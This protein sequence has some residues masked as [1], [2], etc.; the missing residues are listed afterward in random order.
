[1]DWR[2]TLSLASE[3]A[4][5]R[6]PTSLSPLRETWLRFRLSARSVAL[7]TM[8][9]P[10]QDF[11]PNS[12]DNVARLTGTYLNNSGNGVLDG[13][14]YAYNPL[15]QRTNVIRNYW[16][17]SATATVGY[18][19]I[20][21]LISWTAQET[22]GTAR[23]NEQLGYAYDAGGN[24]KQRTNNTLMQ[25]FTVDPANALTN[26]ART[27][28]LTV[29]GNTSLPAH[30]VTV[31]GQP[32]FTYGDFT[33]ASSNGFALADGQNSFTN[34]AS[35]YYGISGVTNTLAANLP[36]SV[37]LQYDP[38]GNL[39]GDGTRCFAYDDENQLTSVWQ[40]NQWRSDF[41][42]DARLRRRIKRDYNWVGG[43]WT[44]TNE[45]RFIYDGQ[46]V[47]QE[48]D[49]N[50][51]AQVTYT[52]GLDLS[53]SLQGAGGIGGLL[54]RTDGTGSTF[55]H[56]DGNGNVTSLVDA[57]QYMVAR[58]LYDPF[59]K[60]L[61][62]WGA[63]ADANLYRFSSKEYH[64]NSG[65][66]YYGFRFYDPN[67]QRWPNPDPIGELGG[68]DLYQYCLNDPLVW[69]DAFGLDVKGG[70]LLM[71][72]NNGY[73]GLNPLFG[74]LWNSPNTALGLLWGG[75]GIPFGAK[76]S[77]ANNALQF[78]N[79]PFQFGG[80]ITLGNVT[81]YRKGMGPKDPLFPGSPYN[82]S[83]H[84]RQHTYQGE[85]LG[86][87]FFPAYGIL[88][89]NSLLHGGDF[90]GAGNLMETGPYLPE[91]TSPPVPPRPWP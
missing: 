76:P 80:D 20:G 62:K 24:L 6:D 67:L 73:G 50:N 11:Q 59:G 44:Q 83:D 52:R 48:W 1:L 16:W 5:H 28:P 8:P 74:Y 37:N 61:G 25:T 34:V 89:V 12:Y 2:Q 4:R 7:E 9:S 49:S 36:A 23:L 63:L 27:G 65:L 71:N 33:F 78:E 47:I 46:A 43:S 45:V 85:Q 86:P 26:V 51:V 56:A 54:A 64:L 17:T 90:F 81:C 10:K 72:M 70:Q 91:T 82:F 75:L 69:D 42:Y 55:Y 66:Y 21:Q 30:S 88:G 40:T 31:N 79:H 84:E 18:D 32:A 29:S 22:N 41:V 53:G 13:Y 15:G 87:F 77:F 68:L 14:A 3:I 19:A 57:S 38:N 35:N 60:L 39:T 58:Y